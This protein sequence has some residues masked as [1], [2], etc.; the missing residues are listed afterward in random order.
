MNFEIKAGV[1]QI[2][3]IGLW[4]RGGL[5]LWRGSHLA[6]MLVAVRSQSQRTYTGL[7]LDLNPAKHQLPG[8]YLSPRMQDSNLFDLERTHVFHSP[9]SFTEALVTARPLPGGGRS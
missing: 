8:D 7:F 3:S 1:G 6:H 4:L 2:L 9:R 5:P